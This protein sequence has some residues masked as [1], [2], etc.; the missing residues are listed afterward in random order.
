MENTKGA[1]GNSK[2][3][4]MTGSDSFLSIG[5]TLGFELEVLFSGEKGSSA[6]ER[7]QHND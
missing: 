2:P 6:E 7:V 5:R 3:K 4:K 1:D